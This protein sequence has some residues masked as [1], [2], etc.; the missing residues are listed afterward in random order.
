VRAPFQLHLTLTFTRT[1]LGRGAWTGTFSTVTFVT[2]TGTVT[3]DSS[4]E[5]WPPGSWLLDR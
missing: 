5:E 4:A 2:R 1:C 3:V